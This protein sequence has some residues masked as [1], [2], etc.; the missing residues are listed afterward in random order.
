MLSKPLPEWVYRFTPKRI[1]GRLWREL[2]GTQGQ[3]LVSKTNRA[4][5]QRGILSTP[6]STLELYAITDIHANNGEGISLRRMEAWLPD[7]A[8]LARRSYAFFGGIDTPLPKRYQRMEQDLVARGALN[9]A[10]IA[11]A[12]QL[13]PGC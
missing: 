4:L 12:W 5:I 1:L 3:D 11:A 10:R 6:L 7:Y 8:C 9:G 2:S 13:R